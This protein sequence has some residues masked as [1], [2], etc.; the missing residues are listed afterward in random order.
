M[1]RKRKEKAR[2]RR[3]CKEEEAPLANN[4]SKLFIISDHLVAPMM[5]IIPGKMLPIASHFYY[6][7]FSSLSRYRHPSLPSPSQTH[8]SNERSG[9]IE[10][11]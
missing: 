8:V 1:K 11:G 5:H 6:V 4:S 9:F 10:G 7:T 3:P 2:D